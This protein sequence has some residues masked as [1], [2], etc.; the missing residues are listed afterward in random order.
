M[1]SDLI[2]A[3]IDTV[4]VGMGPPRAAHRPTHHEGDH[5]WDERVLLQQY[6]TRVQ[7]CNERFRCLHGLDD[8][9]CRSR[10]RVKRNSNVVIV[11]Y[12]A[13]AVSRIWEGLR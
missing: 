1:P 9:M 13:S 11:V 10:R 3:V 2:E 4:G 8:N 12:V 5:I 7:S 6:A